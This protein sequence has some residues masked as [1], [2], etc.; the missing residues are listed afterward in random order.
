MIELTIETT[1][2][3][4][5]WLRL[6]CWGNV[7][8][9]EY[10]VLAEA[11]ERIEKQI[12]T[13]REAASCAL[14]EMGSF[15]FTPGDEEG[16]DRA[17]TLR[18]T[19]EQITLLRDQAVS[20]DRRWPYSRINAAMTAS[21]NDLIGHDLPDWAKRVEAQVTLG[22]MTPADRARLKAQLDEAEHLPA[23]PPEFPRLVEDVMGP[24]MP[25]GG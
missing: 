12:E 22:K 9:R 19:A 6:T 14:G 10:Q 13:V 3:K 4:A 15:A 20:P 16:P 1:L 11:R 18:L 7:S 23:A 8:W 21:L 25:V 17:V 5:L 2:Q 24:P